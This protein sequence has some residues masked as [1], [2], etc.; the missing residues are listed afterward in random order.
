MRPLRHA[1]VGAVGYEGG[2][3]VD[4]GDELVQGLLGIRQVSGGR[5]GLGVAAGCAAGETEEC[6][7]A[8]R[9]RNSVEGS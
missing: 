5:D 2:V 3:G 7:A 9:C 1:R 8:G 4:I 6:A